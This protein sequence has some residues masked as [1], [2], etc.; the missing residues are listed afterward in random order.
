MSIL[1]ILSMNCRGLADSQKRNEMMF[2]T[3]LETKNI[4]YIVCRIPTLPIMNIIA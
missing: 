1:K 2:L 3:F 4:L